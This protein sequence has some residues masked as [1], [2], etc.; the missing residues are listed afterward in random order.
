MWLRLKRTHTKTIW[1]LFLFSFLLYKRDIFSVS[2]KYKFRRTRFTMGN[3]STIKV[4]NNWD[5]KPICM[6]QST[7][8]DLFRFLGLNIEITD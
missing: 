8:R 6:L 4:I 7:V 1:K 2:A 3:K 5:L